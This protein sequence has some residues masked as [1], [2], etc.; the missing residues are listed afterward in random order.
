MKPHLVP[1]IIGWALGIVGGP[2]IFPISFLIWRDSGDWVN[3]F[4]DGWVL[5]GYGVTLVELAKLKRK[6]GEP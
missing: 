6:H 2:L 3:A 1:E 5:L 4:L